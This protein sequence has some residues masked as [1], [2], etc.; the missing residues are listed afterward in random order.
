MKTHFCLQ[1]LLIIF[2]VLCLSSCEKD[3]DYTN[4]IVDKGLQEIQFN[5][6]FKDQEIQLESE[7]W[8]VEYVRTINPSQVLLDV[9]Q[10]LMALGNVGRVDCSKGFISLEKKAADPTKLYVSMTEN[11]SEEPRRILIG[12]KDENTVRQIE[13]TQSTAANYEVTEKIVEETPNTLQVNTIRL[14]AKTI[15]NNTSNSITLNTPI[16]EYFVNVNN[17]SEFTSPIIGTFD[18]IPAPDSLISMIPL[19]YQGVKYWDEKVKFKK[20]TTTTPYLVA[21]GKSPVNK[22]VAPNSKLTVFGEVTYASRACT[23]DIT[24]KNKTTGFIT[25]V[26]GNWK[27]NIPIKAEIKTI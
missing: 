18:Y 22:V 15:T 14:A 17:T 4:V 3:P 16:Q 8:K 13:I 20:W 26:K 9:R 23:F 7:S 2:I 27:Q 1:R 5:T 24:V 6:G 25:N 10:Q 21:N 11:F 12:I 19:V